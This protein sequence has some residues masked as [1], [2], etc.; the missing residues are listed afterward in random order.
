[1]AQVL[2]F[3]VV[4]GGVVQ[5]GAEG[6]AFVDVDA[7]TASEVVGVLMLGAG[8]GEGIFDDVEGEVAGDEGRARHVVT[9][10]VVVA[11]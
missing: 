7:Q 5:T 10:E 4:G 2:V 1:M 11:H 9:G 6:E 8:I 3:G